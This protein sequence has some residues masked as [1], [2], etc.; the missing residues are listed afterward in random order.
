MLGQ[1]VFRRGNK[2]SYINV[3]IL[4]KIIKEKAVTRKDFSFAFLDMRKAFDSI[5]HRELIKVLAKIGIPRKTLVLIANL[6]TGNISELQN[7]DAIRLQRGVVQG[8][9]LSPLLFN[10]TLDEG[11]NSIRDQGEVSFKKTKI[12]HIAFA[13]DLVIFANNDSQI[14][15]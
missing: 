13:D 3:Q 2:G 14:N 6:Y 9:P 7:C 12:G 11:L 4:T 5:K 10:L 1:R 8:D 15:Q